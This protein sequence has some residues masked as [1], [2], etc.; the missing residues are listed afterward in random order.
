MVLKFS[1]Q[2]LD[3]F[4]L[5]QEAHMMDTCLIAEPSTTQDDYNNDVETFDWVNAEQ[6]ACGFN[7]NPSKEVLN[8]VPASEAV[9]RLPALTVIS[10]QARVRITKRF[11]AT[12]SSPVDYEVIG[13][14]RL[15]PSGYLIWLKKVTDGS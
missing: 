12:Q 8:Q 7:A 13:M 10:N 9:I 6:S 15:G 5:V 2:E 14:P 11:G 3:D 1:A 4:E